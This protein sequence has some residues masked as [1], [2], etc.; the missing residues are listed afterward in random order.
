MA[1]LAK[2]PVRIAFAGGGTDV[3]PYPSDYGGYVINSTINIHFRC[4]LTKRNDNL[5][6]LYSNDTFFPYKFD[7]IKISN[8]NYQPSNLF[9]AIFY[10]VK[11]TLGM[12]VYVH[13]EPPKKAGLGAS[14]SLCTC[15]ISG[16]FELEGKQI[17]LNNIAEDAYSVEQNI[18]NNVGGRQDQYA[19]VYGGFNG[20]EFSG[21]SK[22]AIKKL[23]LSRSFKKEL[24]DNLIL[25][26]TGEPHT[27]GNIVREQ[28]KSYME[29]KEESKKSL[30]K[31][32]SIAYLMRDA[33]L[34]EN[35]ELFGKLLTEDLINKKKF[36]PLL[37][38]EYMENLN[39]LF[40]KH[41]GIGGRVCG[42][43]GGGSM[44][45]L[46]DPKRKK[47][48]ESILEKQ[49]GKLI[50]FNFVEKGLEVLSI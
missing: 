34:S 22:V 3:E 49:Q 31:L 11:P 27:S 40:L 4:M 50:N 26:Y 17:N 9:E 28:V 7:T 19:A 2:T 15:L 46:I 45:W 47:Q 30:D 25:F 16:I 38:T 24:E 12:D 23:K 42:A 13:G 21:N 18:L 1:I 36:N 5:I 43:G 48:I 8:N 37:T 39:R 29:N 6:N 35:F 44:V 14:A 33:L 32:K 10:L 20:L 41:G